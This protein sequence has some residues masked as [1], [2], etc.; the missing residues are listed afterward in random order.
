MSL[1]YELT[2]ELKDAGFP[3][4][5]DGLGYW[6]TE[7]SVIINAGIRVVDPERCYIPTLSELIE[8]CGSDLIT[9]E[10][11]Q[12]EDGVISWVAYGDPDKI[13]GDGLTPEEAVANLWIQL[14]KK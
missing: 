6:Y 3:Q 4:T 8:A 12:N 7:K 9:L 11:G 5:K 14:Q 13:N 10:R 1:S 2:K